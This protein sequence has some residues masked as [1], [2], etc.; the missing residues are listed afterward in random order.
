[1]RHKFGMSCGR[2]L[3][4]G[5]SVYGTSRTVSKMGIEAADSQQFVPMR[6]PFIFGEIE[7]RL[8]YPQH[9]LLY[10]ENLDL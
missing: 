6:L 7:L 5:A 2:H 1:M 4:N 9:L 10:S 3:E 8:T